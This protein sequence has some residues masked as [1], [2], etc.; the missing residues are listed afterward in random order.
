MITQAHDKD[1][2]QS[3]QGGSAHTSPWLSP[4]EAAKYVGISPARLQ[5]SVRSGDITHYRISQKIVRFR[6]E[7]L[8]AWIRSKKK[9]HAA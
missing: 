9:R 8:D 2:L 6:I 5:E 3:T 7:D 1:K 4:A